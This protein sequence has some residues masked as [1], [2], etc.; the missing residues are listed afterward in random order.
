MRCLNAKGIL[1]AVIGVFALTSAALA[2]PIAV[3]VTNASEPV[4]CAEKDNVTLAFASPLVKTFRIEA[5]HP[6]YIGALQRDSFE[7]DWTACDMKADPVF[8]SGAAVT[9]RRT[10]Y[11]EPDIWVVGWTFPTYWRPSTAT[12]K[13]GD[14]VESGL[15]MLQVWTIRPMGGEE[16]LVLYP[17]DGYWRIRPKAPEGRAPTAFGSSF[18]IGPVEEDGRPLVKIKEIVIDPKMRTLALTFERGGKATVTLATVDHNRTALSV[19]LDKVV[20]GRPFAMM[21]SMYITEFNN[22]VAQ[23]AVKE[24]GARGWRQEGVMNFTRAT[25]T[26]VW[27]GRTAISRH[28]SSSPDMV[29]SGFDTGKDSTVKAPPTTPPAKAK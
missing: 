19:S 16:V 6:A 7:A 26:D 14:R 29:F 27:A 1:A 18:L 21:R 20:S 11:E 4:L 23:V 8:K 5:A 28:N 2:D 22:D 24:K 15:H 17:Q 10:I 25:A 9:M 12:V 3:E 13:I